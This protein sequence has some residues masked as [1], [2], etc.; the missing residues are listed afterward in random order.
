[1]AGGGGGS[2]SKCNAW[3]VWG[4]GVSGSGGSG[5]GHSASKKAKGAGAVFMDEKRR[6]EADRIRGQLERAV[7]SSDWEKV[8]ECW[9]VPQLTRE[10]KAPSSYTGSTHL[11]A[12]HLKFRR[13]RLGGTLM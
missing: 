6:E 13:R 8:N 11:P 7:S 5:S 1:M 9:G 3:G 4:S 12:D 10:E 2:S